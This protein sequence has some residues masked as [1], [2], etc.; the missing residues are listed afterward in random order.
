MALLDLAAFEYSAFVCR[1]NV[2][3]RDVGS[4]SRDL[5]E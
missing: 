1:Y 4:R 3:I 5:A 2:L